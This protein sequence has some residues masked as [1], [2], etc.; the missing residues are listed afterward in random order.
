MK[1]KLNPMQHIKAVNYQ[2]TSAGV[3]HHGR[4]LVASSTR[5]GLRSAE[6]RFWKQHTHVQ[7]DYQEAA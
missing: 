6:R 5:A 2:W 1:P 3:T 4:T 7:K